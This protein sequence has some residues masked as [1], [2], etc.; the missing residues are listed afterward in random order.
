MAVKFELDPKKD[1]VVPCKALKDFNNKFLVE[2]IKDDDAF[3]RLFA[4]E[5]KGKKEAIKKLSESINSLPDTGRV[6]FV[7]RFLV[8]FGNKVNDAAEEAFEELE[9]NNAFNDLKTATETYNGNLK[10][11]TLATANEAKS[12]QSTLINRFSPAVAEFSKKYIASKGGGGG[13]A[14]GGAPGTSP[15]K[16]L[17][18]PATPPK[19]LIVNYTN[20]KNSWSLVLSLKTNILLS[21][22]K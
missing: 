12:L 22:L 16:P 6:W 5:E 18:P 7:K 4:G 14:P 17:P 8:G 13:A 3:K 2:A 11:A 1:Q 15:T 9:K 19:A 21:W 10:Q 20:L